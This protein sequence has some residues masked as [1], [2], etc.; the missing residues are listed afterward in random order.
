MPAALAWV[1]AAVI[2]GLVSR[3]G[4]V[5]PPKDRG[6]HSAPTPTSGG[7]G[8]IAGAC[9]GLALA[10]SPLP[11][12]QTGPLTLLLAMAVAVGLL[13]ALD[14]VIDIGARTKLGLQTALALVFALFVARID[15]LPLAPGL[16]LHLWPIIAVL[17]TAL[18]IV[19]TVNGL[20]FMDGANGLAPGAAIIILAGLSLLSAAQG[21]SAIAATALMAAAA[22][23]GF[24]PW[25]LP[26]GRV[27][28]G[29]AGALFSGFLI[30]G[31]AVLA[32]QPSAGTRPLSAFPVVFACLP[33][34][35]DVF[36]TLLARARRGVSLLSA[37]RE[38]LFQRWLMARPDRTHAG[39]ALRFWGLT[40]GAT[41]I[42]IVAEQLP[43]GF[44][45]GVLAISVA[46]SVLMWRTWSQ[47]LA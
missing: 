11:P 12:V 7:I 16:D 33:L 29:D 39:L 24:L 30:A 17:G 4:P 18:W 3:W 40:L 44:Q 37:H 5:D 1:T 19:V 32:A 27:F 47:R 8:I 10:A 9:A 2:A 22:G 21:H 38:H 28:Q 41:V 43:Q 34:L 6:A 36:L 46:V 26:G 20:N 23:L 13:G 31:L 15:T 42:G 35:T 45:A 25:N 14:D